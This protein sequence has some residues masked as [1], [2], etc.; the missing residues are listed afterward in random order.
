VGQPTTWVF[1]SGR[2][3]D[4]VLDGIRHGHTFISYQ[5]PSYG[6]PQVT[7]QADTNKP[8]AWD[9]MM[10]DTVSP[11]SKLRAHVKG[12]PGAWL[13]L[14]TNGGKTLAKVQVTSPDFSYDFSLPK[15]SQSTWVLA[16][17]YGEDLSD[18]RKAACEDAVGSQTSYCRNRLMVLGL[19]SPIY[20]G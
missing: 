16:E 11:K 10:G 2:S 18:Q 3:S 5:P 7:L 4:G 15:G 13:K 17:L 1:A 9:S 6:G 19:T 14:T 8:G 20:F 12:A